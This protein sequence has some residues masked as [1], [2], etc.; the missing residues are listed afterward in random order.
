MKQKIIYLAILAFTF[1]TQAM[2]QGFTLQ[3]RVTDQDNNPV[4]LATVSVLKQGKVAFTSLKGEFSM[5]LQ[6]AD[7]VVVKFTMIGYKPKVRILRHPKGK[8]T[9]QVVL[10][11]DDNTLAE[12]QVTGQK[13]QTGQT[14]EL[15]AEDAKLAPSASGNGVESLIQQQAGVSTHNELSSQ[16]NVRGGA[17]DENSVYINNVE[18]YRPL[19]VRSGQ[20]EGL[21]MTEI[22]RASCR[23]RV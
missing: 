16:Y 6:S 13:I 21:S 5:H 2:A 11:T 22:G 10:F 3:G 1:A 15:K 19:L 18:V 4:E 17:F 7:S 9:L 23:E 20:Q 12:V 8:Q 14:E